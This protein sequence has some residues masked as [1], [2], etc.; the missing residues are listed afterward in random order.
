M[1]TE[2][3]SRPG[4]PPLPGDRV[5]ITYDNGAVEEKEF[6]PPVTLPPDPG[7][8]TLTVLLAETRKAVGHAFS[9]VITA[10]V[11]ISDV[12]DVP[13]L[14]AITGKVEKVK[15][16]TFSNG[17]ATEQVAFERSGYFVVSETALNA[18]LPPHLRMR[19]AHGD[20]ELTV[21]E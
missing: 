8:I 12:F 5:R 19:L 18:K 16:I 9:A 6:H 11:P 17:V 20:L 13:I 2:N 4:L 3:L 7:E 21:Y 10:S 15:R 14:D 1:I